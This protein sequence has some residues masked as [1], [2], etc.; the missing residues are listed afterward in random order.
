MKFLTWPKNP[1]RLT[2][3]TGVV[4]TACDAV[5]LVLPSVCG[6]WRRQQKGLPCTCHR[7]TEWEGTRYLPISQETDKRRTFHCSRWLTADSDYWW[8]LSKDNN[9]FI[10]VVTADDSLQTVMTYIIR[11]WLTSDSDD[12]F[13]LSDD[14]SLPTIMAYSSSWYYDISSHYVMRWWLGSDSDDIYRR[15]AEIINHHWLIPGNFIDA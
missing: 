2:P 12:L 6:S 9:W 8:W 3:G 4:S 14:D 13:I 7:L 1:S 5:E 11:W 10:H 15:S